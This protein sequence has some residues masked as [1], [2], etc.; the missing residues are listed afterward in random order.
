MTVLSG[1][2]A[3]QAATVAPTKVTTAGTSHTSPTVTTTV[4]NTAVVAL[5]L[6]KETV[7]ATAATLTT[8][9]GW[10]ADSVARTAFTASLGSGN[11]TARAHHLTTPGAAGSYGGATSTSSVN[12]FSIVYTVTAP[13]LS[14]QPPTV[15]AGADQTGLEPGLPF[16]LTA[17]ASDPDGTVTSIVWAQTGGSP[18][19]P[20]TATGTTGQVTGVAPATTGGATLTFTATATDNGG[21][22]ATDTVTVS[23]LP[24][25]EKI[26]IGS[27][28]TPASAS[29]IVFTPTGGGGGGTAPDPDPPAGLLR[30]VATPEPDFFPPRIRLD[31]TDTR[32]TPATELTITRLDPDGRYRPVRT[33]DDGPLPLSGGV[34]TLYDYEPKGFGVQVT[35]STDVPGGPTV[36]TSL[37]ADGIWLVHRGV[38]SRSVRVDAVS[39]IGPRTREVQ[40]GKFVIL[41]RNDPIVVTGGARST[42]AG[43]IGVRTDTDAQRRAMD[44]LLDDASPVLLNLPPGRG[45]GFDPCYLALGTTDED[46]PVRYGPVP[47]R[48]WTLPY[49][50]IGRPVGGIRAAVTW[51]DIATEGAD[52]YTAAPGS[53]Y[54]TWQEIADAGLTWAQLAAPTT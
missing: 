34:A 16:T 51:D 6:V 25:A 54:M 28:W 44:L 14:N 33:D 36:T 2:S 29:L 3:L 45:W 47:L 48:E 18:A 41:E 31:I 42:P 23:V 9:A 12:S 22:T 24:V 27:T 37:D 8:P 1:T 5:W 17:T 32:T 35:Y 30:I 21:A 40:Q 13:P 49:Q 19:V 15:N 43:M 20:V 7:S 52:D 53:Q 11:Y 4:A 10:T 38:P 26:L 50:V 39:K 46:R